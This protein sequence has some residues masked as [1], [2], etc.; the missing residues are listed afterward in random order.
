M[1]DR[2]SAITRI[3]MARAI[4]LRDKKPLGAAELV[5]LP[6]AAPFLVE[7]HF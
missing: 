4:Q 6:N 5:K 7:D 1:F 3:K 2:R